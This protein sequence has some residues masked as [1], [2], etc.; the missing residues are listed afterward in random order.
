M[1]PR[2]VWVW[3]KADITGRGAMSASD[4]KRTSPTGK[5]RGNKKL[6]V[7]AFPGNDSGR[8]YRQI[9]LCVSLPSPF[10]IAAFA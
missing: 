7:S 6:L 1:E 10:M 4:P 8:P 5:R 2:D 3:H 9:L